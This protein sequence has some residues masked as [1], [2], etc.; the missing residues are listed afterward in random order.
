MGGS[1]VG[2]V[3]LFMPRLLLMTAAE[4]LAFA[5]SVLRTSNS[6]LLSALGR[7]LVEALVPLCCR[8]V[9]LSVGFWRVRTRGVMPG[10]ENPIVVA[11]HVSLV[12]GFVLYWLLGPKAT[13]IARRENLANLPLYG[14]ILAGLGIEFV[15]RED[16]ESRKQAGITI[17]AHCRNPGGRKLIIF[18][19]GK[20]SG[21]SDLHPF[22]V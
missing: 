19:E 10:P 1:R 2:G 13:F 17:E 3:L 22:K 21:G 15:D 6:D 5:V 9:L 8:C 7:R 4:F 20:T 18:P 14:R 12:D 11:N 16:P